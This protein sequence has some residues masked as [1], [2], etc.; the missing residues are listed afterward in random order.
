MGRVFMSYATD[1]HGTG[2]RVLWNGYLCPIDTKL[3]YMVQIMDMHT[4]AQ[5]VLQLKLEVFGYGSKNT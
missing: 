5:P 2:I 3:I 4:C 1:I